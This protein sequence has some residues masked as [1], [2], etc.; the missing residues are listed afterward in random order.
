[1]T[2]VPLRLATYTL[3]PVAGAKA[4]VLAALEVDVAGLAPEERDG[5]RAGRL[6]LRVETTPREGGEGWVESLSL[7]S[8]PSPEGAGAARG[9]WHT[10]RVEFELPA[11]WHQ[12][13]ATAREP[14]SGRVGVVSQKVQVPDPIGFRLS[15]PILSDAV[16][17]SGR[18]TSDPQPLAVAHRSFRGGSGRP[19]FCAFEVIGAA[20]ATDTGRSQVFVGFELENGAGNVVAAL[21][22]TA[23]A[24]AGDGRLQAVL[25]LPLAEL[26]AGE[27]ALHLR[28][29]DRVAQKT[30]AL[31]EGFAVVRAATVQPSE[32]ARAG[33]STEASPV[34]EELR[35][36]L[37]RAGRHVVGY[38]R[39]F[40]H[41]FAEESYRQEYTDPTGRRH[42]RQSRADVVFVS[43]PGAVPWTVFRDVIEVDGNPVGDR[44][45]RM[46]RLFVESPGT[47]VEKARRI[48][49]ES[50]RYN[51]GP[52][53]RTVNSPPSPSRSCCRTSRSA[54]RSRARDATPSGTPARSRWRTSSRRGRRSCTTT[55]AT[56]FRAVAA[57]GSIPTPA[58]SC[59]ACWS[60]TRT[61]RP[62]SRG[63][64][65]PWSTGASRGWTSWC[66]TR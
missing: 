8:P 60:T 21:P 64:A 40:S 2:D 23:L 41:V 39:A 59:A 12:V 5:R 3:E 1:M 14:S 51:L 57:S 49:D 54:S 42:A 22:P 58:R 26:P 29:E 31:R 30:E 47:A 52:L 9:Q 46:K 56:T 25:A 28:T 48:L 33:A 24:P 53:R 32:G 6:E 17:A 16:P 36:V 38:E 34:P 7:E 50:G 55:R 63:H 19:L 13:R 18:E 20:T 66:R 62:G 65:S 44:A 35:E 10:V 15:T 27:Y 4:R 45:A 37:E 43:L 11:G 61:A